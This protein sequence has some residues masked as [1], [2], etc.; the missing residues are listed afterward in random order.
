MD[1]ALY[2]VGASGRVALGDLADGVEYYHAAQAAQTGVI[3]LT[4]VR[5][6]A[7]TGKRTEPQEQSVA[8][9]EGTNTADGDTPWDPSQG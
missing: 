9:P 4:P 8:D 7:A 3:T 6:H 5:I 2:K 1:L